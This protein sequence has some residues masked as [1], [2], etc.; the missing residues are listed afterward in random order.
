MINQ[1][2]KNKTNLDDVFIIKRF[3]YIDKRGIFTKTFNQK[4][5]S[6]LNLGENFKIKES[7]CS[8]SKKH[9]IRGM[10]YQS[11]PHAC[12]KIV[13]VVRGEILDV[14]V[15]IIK[16]GKNKNLGQVFST[17]LSE[18]NKKSLYV[19]EGYAHGFLALSDDV[20]VVYHQSNE[21][22]ESSDHGIR[23][24]SFGFNWPVSNPILSDRDQ[25]LI[26]LNEI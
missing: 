3:S 11:Y 17:K 4:M 12:S 25:K 19:P 21:Y 22:V 16:N 14:I 23:Y 2:K 24:D 7:L 8:T 18:H 26:K 5:F 6:G 13:S 15:G 10:H 20:V 9:V 1:F